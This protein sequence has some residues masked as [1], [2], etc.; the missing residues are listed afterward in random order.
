MRR[1]YGTTNIFAEKELR[2][3]LEA[4][5][6]AVISSI[7]NERDD[8]LLNVNDLDYV[9]YKAEEAKV[10]P[11]EIHI[12]QIYA[13]S[14]EQMITA[15]YFPSSFWV[16]RGSSYKKDV[17][18]FHIPISGNQ[19]L[20]E[21][22]PSSRLVWSMP[23]QLGRDEFTFEIINFSDDVEKI[24]REKDSNIQSIVKQL[25]NVTSE[26]TNYNNSIEIQIKNAFE[27]RKQKLLSKNNVLA[28]LGVPIKKAG[29][30]SPT[31]SVPTPEIRKKISVAKPVV[32]EAGFTPEPSLD[33]QA[34][35]QILQLIHDVGK[36]FE[37]LPSL[38][39]GKEEEHLRDHFLMMLEPNF[40]GSATGETFNKTGKTDILLR[41]EG[42][43][44]FIA[45]CKFW[46]GKKVFLDTITQLLG[47]LTWRDS[48]ASVIMFVPNKDF[49]SVLVTAKQEISEHENY[50]DFLN[51][52]DETWMNYRFHLNGDRNRLVSLAV[53][54]YHLPK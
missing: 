20:I 25:S 7:E 44:V 27:A 23:I 12:D 49:S 52:K 30:V 48:K 22:A 54:L 33:M 16:E 19:E 31:F 17:I 6:Q 8:Y 37:R 2:D 13:S 51:A 38:Y 5:K 18:K 3:Y 9:G 40:E 35:N 39:S 24:T 47:Y 21:C 32:S 41:H 26:V 1:N 50:V 34:Y 43:N 4:R 15:E 53:M 28:S 45:E 42:S 11:L 29:G 10:E 46:K 14:S 36:A